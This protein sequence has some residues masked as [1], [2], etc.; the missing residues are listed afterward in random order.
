MKLLFST[1][2][3]YYL[4]IKDVFTI[5]KGAGFDG[6]DLVIDGRFADD[7][8]TAKVLECLDILPV[9]SVHAPYA[10]MSSWGNAAEV[11]SRT[12]GIA[13]Q[14][15]A[16]V[17]NFHPPSWYSMEMQFVRWFRK[18]EDFQKEAAFPDCALAVENMPL[19]G[20]RL[21]LAPYIFNAYEDLI[22]FGIERNLYFTFDVTHLATFEADV[23]AAFLTFLRTKR[24][25]NVHMSDFGNFKSH[26]F[27]GNGNL[28][29][30]R[31]LNTMRRL[32]YDG[33]VTLE[34]APFE[35]PRTRDW[36]VRML[37]YQV[38]FLKLHLGEA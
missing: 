16:T 18:V 29:I 13:R 10:K 23:V 6:C 25:K 8:H 31:L 14:A 28:P 26:L 32:D 37:A 7:R 1:G 36:L 35:L 27:L 11:L 20:K 38:S 5:A 9:C 15:G 17:V 4:P 12:F 30:V 3:L 19:L 22:A 2:S 21:M 34:L 33:F 24:L